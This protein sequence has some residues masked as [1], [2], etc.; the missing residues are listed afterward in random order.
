MTAEGG[1]GRST[2]SHWSLTHQNA[3]LTSRT[4]TVTMT[5]GGDA[6]FK[7]VVVRAEEIAARIEGDLTSPLM[8]PSLLTNEGPT[9]APE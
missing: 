9:S 7:G 2:A 1:F 3:H 4:G 8:L 6:V 5:V